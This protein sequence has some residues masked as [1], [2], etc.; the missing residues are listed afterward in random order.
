MA[1]A[2][3]TAVTIEQFWSE[4]DH[5][6]AMAGDEERW[7]GELLTLLVDAER[8]EA[9]DYRGGPPDMH[10]IDLLFGDGRRIA[11]EVE[12]HGRPERT[13]FDAERD[14]TN[15]V[16]A[17]SLRCGWVVDFDLP[18]DE[19]ADAQVVAQLFNAVD[20]ELEPTLARI[21]R[22]GL[23]DHVRPVRQVGDCSRSDEHPIRAHMRELRVRSA[24]PA[25]W[26][27]DGTIRLSR[28]EAISARSPKN[29]AAQIKRHIE[30]DHESLERARERGADETHLFLWMPLGVTRGDTAGMAFSPIIPEDRWLPPKADLKGL[31]SVWVS[32]F[33]LP[34]TSPELQG[35]SSPIWQLTDSGWRCWTRDWQKSERETP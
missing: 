29:V 23:H 31:D 6:A 32:K 33:T 1:A 17:P 13:A 9:V 24:F 5:R 22:E 30:N 35:F 34:A 15:P 8:W 16:Q 10:D 28:V 27:D 20:G 26:L 11:V 12:I 4:H 14:R 2:D 25:P 19:A 3:S 21:E 18:D 7:A